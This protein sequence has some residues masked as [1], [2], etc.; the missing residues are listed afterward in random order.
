MAEGRDL[1][2]EPSSQGGI[3]VDDKTVELAADMEEVALSYFH[4]NFTEFNAAFLEEIQRASQNG[5][6]PIEE[7]RLWL[8]D[9]LDEKVTH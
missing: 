1:I 2:E 4:G 8:N 9:F 5:D 6:D 7:V 3:I